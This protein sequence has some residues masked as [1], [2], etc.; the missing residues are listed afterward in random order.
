M[1]VEIIK[2][3]GNVLKTEKDRLICFNKI[4]FNNGLKKIIICSAMG[5]SGFPYSTD[6]LDALVTDISDV[7]KDRLLGCG[8][9]ISSV[10]MSSFFNKLGKN[11]YSLSYLDTGICVLK[12]NNKNEIVKLSNKRMLEL[13]EMYDVLLIPGFIAFNDNYDIVTLG[14]GNSDLTAMI[15]AKMLSINKVTLYKDVLGVYPFMILPLLNY[16]YYKQLNY[17]EVDEMINSGCKIISKD[18]LIYAKNSNIEINITGY[19][20]NENGSII[21]NN[22]VEKKV[23]GFFMKG[24]IFDVISF[25]PCYVKDKLSEAFKTKHIILK[26]EYIEGNHYYFKLESSQLLLAKKII[27][28][29]FFLEFIK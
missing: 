9:I 20:S 4:D 21:N 25:Y 17:N 5:R 11:A 2:L 14:R 10:V 8:E 19:N 13:L 16:E 3:G 28:D 23:I 7:E 22:Y 27:V 12:S 26:K 6:N 24:K 29:T 15:V 18:A 1:N